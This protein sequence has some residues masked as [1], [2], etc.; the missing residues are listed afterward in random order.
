[1]RKKKPIQPMGKQILAFLSSR[2]NR[3][4][5]L[6][7]I[8]KGLGL[9]SDSRKALRVSLNEMAKKGTLFKFRNKHYGMAKRAV[10]IEG[11]IDIA[12]RGYGFVRPE[13][14][15]ITNGKDIFIKRRNLSGAMHGDKVVCVVTRE[16][17]EG[18]EGKIIEIREH[19]RKTLAGQIFFE[20][21]GATVIPCN[22]K[23]KRVVY[24]PATAAF[25]RKAR[26]GD[27]V[28]V[29]IVDY[30]TPREPLLGEVIDIIGGEGEK[31]ID[32]M[33]L[34]R[35]SGGSL[36]FPDEVLEES[37]Q[38]EAAI[39]V[40]QIRK[41]LDLRGVRTFT[42]DPVDA[43]DF[44][45]ALSIE[46]M[47]NGN[48]RL[49]VHIADVSYYVK[50][51]NLTDREAYR[52]GTSIYPVD[53]VVPMLPE[54]L[55]NILCS[56]RP[57]E[58]RLTMSVVAELDVNGNLKDYKITPSIIHSSFR[59][60]YEE[61]EGILD[62][63]DHYALSIYHSIVD[64]L[65]LLKRLTDELFTQR[66]ARGALD[67]DVSET[68]VLFNANGE[69]VDVRRKTRLESHRIVEECMLLGNEIV[70]RH[71]TDSDIPMMYRV[72]DKPGTTK[73]KTL[74]TLLKTLGI[75]FNPYHKKITVQFQAALEHADKFESGF[76][77]RRLI[78]RSMMR[79]EYS[80][81]NMGHFGLAASCYTHFTSPIRRYP[82]LIVHRILKNVLGRG[83][84]EKRIAHYRKMLP[85]CARYCSETERTAADIENESIRIKALE[86]MKQFL[87][88]HFESVISGVSSQGFWVELERYPVEGFVQIARLPQDRYKY[89]QES[90][91]LKGRKS[92]N[93]FSLGAKI[94]V[95]VDRVDISN[96]QIDLGFVKK[97]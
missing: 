21:R 41:R 35:D 77:A 14:P 62:G 27:Y 94:L 78:L 81:D 46:R 66:L 67:L 68:E 32:V 57:N 47:D 8:L 17:E 65:L 29:H 71:I 74:S 13:N 93:S 59:M 82:D 96:R 53:R 9:D 73:L 38:I 1:M 80:E 97:I 90:Q 6:A 24:I 56:L 85:E 58:D 64:D 87:G 60:T 34:V 76:I 84:S 30:T 12:A 31:G 16:S 45:D 63:T 3:V 72:H 43:K 15:D 83:L 5:R 44:D 50:E 4:Y 23:I 25:R 37:E 69:V 42:I 11:K 55:S 79:A 22:R 33:V 28:L 54:R 92:R 19:A 61:V 88:D 49:G 2:P 26:D 86:F 20:K 48:Y 95:S 91:I 51:G 7:E 40:S 52:R 36:V 75:D 70:A 39:P 18:P 10:Y 89:Y